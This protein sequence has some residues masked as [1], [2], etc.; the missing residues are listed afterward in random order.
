MRLKIHFE[1]PGL[2]TIMTITCNIQKQHWLRATTA[3][4]MRLD[5]YP[6]SIQNTFESNIEGLGG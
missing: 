1:L 3:L 6:A 5:V 2:N 4:A